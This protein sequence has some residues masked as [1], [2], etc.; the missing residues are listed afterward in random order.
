MLSD[1]EVIYA[2]QTH[3][4]RPDSKDAYLNNVYVAY[5][6]FVYWQINCFCSKNTVELIKTQPTLE[7]DVTLVGS[8][9]VN[10]GD[11]D[12]ALH[13]W[14]YNG[15]FA[16]IDEAF[17]ILNKNQV[18]VTTENLFGRCYATNKQVD[19]FVSG[20]H[21]SV[22]NMA[23]VMFSDWLLLRN[24]KKKAS[25][26]VDCVFLV[27]RITRLCWWNKGKWCV[28]GIYSICWRS[29]IGRR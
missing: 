7:K 16:K 27:C 28:H 15:G 22:N 20:S 25:A 6:S 5:Y 2:L 1:K 14:Q 4:Y 18:D 9:T 23:V 17:E 29:A 24:V 8:W 26:H 11:Q 21:Q 3:N 12:Q 13:L 19:C 10:V